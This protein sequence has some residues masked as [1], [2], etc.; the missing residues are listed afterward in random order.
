MSAP[1]LPKLSS[2]TDIWGPPAEIPSIL[3]FS[4]VPYAP[5]SKY[6]KLGK[7]ADW[8]AEP[9]KDGKDQKRQQYGRNFRDPYHAYGASS[10]LFFTNEDAENI[11]SFSIVDS[12][13]QPANRPRGQNAVLKTRGRGGGITPNVAA[14]G[15]ARNAPQRQYNAS[16]AA[17]RQQDRT[18]RP[19]Q[20]RRFGWRDYDKPQKS[21][22]ASVNISDDWELIQAIGFNDLQK[23]SFDNR[24]GDDIETYGYTHFYN[25]ALDKPIVN[26]KLQQLDRLVYNVTTS[27][28]PVIQELADKGSG[29]V[30]ATDSIISLLMCATKS[31]IPWDIIINKRNGKIFL[32]KREGGPLDFV[33][34]DEN[35]AEAPSDSTDKDNINSAANLGYEATYINHNFNVN[36]VT[37]SSDNKYEFN[38]PNPFYV[39][40][41]Q[42]DSDPLLAH[43][44]RYRT[45]NLADNPEEETLSL[46]IRSKIDA[47]Q[48]NV[49]G[50]PSYVTVNALNEY[51]GANG[52]LEWKNKF[53]NQR[54]A[55]VAAEMKNNLSKLSRWSV[56]AILAGASS[57]K[58]GF[59]SRVAP[60]DNTQHVIVGVLAR[61]PGQFASQ[62]NL[63][64]NNGWGIV[65]S[66]INIATELEDNGKY[67]LIKD[68]NNPS[69]KLYK[70]PPTTFEEESEN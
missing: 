46:I 34:V 22:D 2:T 9:G 60:K 55:I 19:G 15:Q 37:E 43:G 36:A 32:D 8:A 42:K 48:A 16:T 62:I 35:A 52:I 23:L 54:G 26:I 65:K 58:I 70:V 12:S 18:Q 29:T 47:V 44:Y 53:V 33:S 61:D 25:R 3:R 21:K 59:V 66:I 13:K 24:N 20:R 11:S 30:F 41:D 17:P 64:L 63:N 38:K 40:E 5:F 45:F 14:T 4:E 39:A 7:V 51:G 10:A 49:N 1:K 67:V 57:M 50:S 68:P 27:D 6:D 28:D 69:I 56:Q 31:V